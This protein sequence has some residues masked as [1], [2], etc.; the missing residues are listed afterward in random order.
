MIFISHKQA[1]PSEELLFYLQNTIGL[2]DDA[3]QLGIRQSLA[4]QAPLPI[5]LWTFGLISL[6]Q[7]EE[8]FD[9]QSPRK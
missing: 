8:L 4:E 6:K 5:I 7:L 3:L 9:W 2:S 1:P